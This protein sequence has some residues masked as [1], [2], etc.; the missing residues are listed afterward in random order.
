MG[1]A[2]LGGG[3]GGF[4]GGE[5]GA[6]GLGGCGEGFLCGELFLEGGYEV[7]CG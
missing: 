6:E 3:E 2:G 4:G 7:V 1:D 5:G